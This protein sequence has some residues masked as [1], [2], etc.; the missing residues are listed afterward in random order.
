MF[1]GL[2]FWFSKKSLWWV[3]FKKSAFS[4]RWL[5]VLSDQKM[6]RAKFFFTNFQSTSHLLSFDANEIF[7]LQKLAVLWLVKVSNHQNWPKTKMANISGC[8]GS[9]WL[10]FCMGDFFYHTYHLSYLALGQ[11]LRNT[12]WTL[13][14]SDSRTAC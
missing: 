8:D 5:A 4:Y 7:L 6:T 12:M 9:I 3:F 1:E 2:I 14:L 13:L 10:K 11:I